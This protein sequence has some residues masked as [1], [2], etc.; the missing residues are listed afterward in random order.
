MRTARLTILIGALAVLAACTRV[1][2]IGLDGRERECVRIM[3]HLTAESENTVSM[4]SAD[5]APRRYEGEPVDAVTVTYVDGP[6]RRLITCLYSQGTREMVDIRYQGES[7][8]GP[9]RAEV[10]RAVR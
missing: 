1:Q 8:S 6:A 5:T 9:R 7:L 3:E 10:I 4:D 2:T